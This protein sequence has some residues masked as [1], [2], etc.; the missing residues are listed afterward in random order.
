MNVYRTRCFI[1]VLNYF[2]LVDWKKR[3]SQNIQHYE[4]NRDIIL[5]LI[6]VRECPPN[7]KNKKIKKYKYK[8]H[9]YTPMYT[10]SIF[11]IPVV[12]NLPQKF[13][14]K[15]LVEHPSLQNSPMETFLFTLFWFVLGLHKV[16]KIQSEV[17]PKIH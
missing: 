2:Y 5:S 12:K 14:T 13:H 6:S 9:I 10:H 1:N 8:L 4:T 11:C 17:S 7:K 16:V 15:F 3:C